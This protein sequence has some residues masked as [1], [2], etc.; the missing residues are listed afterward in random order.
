M[1][2]IKKAS[3]IL[4]IILVIVF[5]YFEYINY[6]VNSLTKQYPNIYNFFKKEAEYY[7]GETFDLKSRTG[8]LKVKLNGNITDITNE[9]YQNR[10]HKLENIPKSNNK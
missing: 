3:N 4:L 7:I 9:I 1:K 8:L 10:Y 6:Q 5:L 2:I